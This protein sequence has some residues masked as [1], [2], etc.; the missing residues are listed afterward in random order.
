[1][2]AAGAYRDRHIQRPA[3]GK[4]RQAPQQQLLPPPEQI[5]APV[6]GR[7]NR[8]V[9]W[10][11][12]AVGG[13][14]DAGIVF[15]PLGQLVEGQQAGARRGQLERQWDAVHAVADACQRWRVGGRDDERVVDG[16]GP[17]DEELCGRRPG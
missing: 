14:Q 7:A 10:Q 15:E 2:S 12:G 16:V 13:A 17:F 6:D 3:A 9:L 11:A 5:V 8:S 4:H 1:M